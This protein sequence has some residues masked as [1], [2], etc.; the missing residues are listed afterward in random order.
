MITTATDLVTAVLDGVL[1]ALLLVLV[2]HVAP[3]TALAIGLIVSFGMLLT[4]T[5]HRRHLRSLQPRARCSPQHAPTS[6]R[7][8]PRRTA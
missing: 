6:P 2:G 5:A 8:M 1:V 3:A 7:W 4:F